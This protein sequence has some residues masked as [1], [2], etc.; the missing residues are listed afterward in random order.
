[1]KLEHNGIQF[2][3]VQPFLMF[4]GKAILKAFIT[5]LTVGGPYRP[6]ELNAHDPLR[7][8]YAHLLLIVQICGRYARLVASNHSNR[9]RD[10]VLLDI[11]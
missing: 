10:G 4:R 7:H 2:Y 6:I 11:L 1:M 8:L 5:A 3:N 9:V